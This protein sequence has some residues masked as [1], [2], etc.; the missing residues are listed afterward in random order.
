MKSIM[1]RN[2]PFYQAIK[3]WQSLFSI[4][5][6]FIFLLTGHATQAQN[7]ILQGTIIDKETREVIPFGVI[8]LQNTKLGTTTD[9]DG[10]YKLE[11]IPPTV[12]NIIISSLGYAEMVVQEVGISG[13]KPTVLN[14]ELSP[15][16][17]ELREAEVGVSRFERM[18]E[19]P[20]SKI[21]IRAAEIMRNPGGNRDISK[22]IQSFPGVASSVSFRNDLIIRG[23]APNE[24]RFYLDGIE[25]PNINHF[26]TQ[27]S[28]GGPVGLINVNFV[29]DVD[30]YSGAFPASRGNT[31]SS[32][33]EF[34]QK[35]G[36]PDRLASTLMVGSSDFGLTLDGPISER[37]DFIFSVRR[38]YLQFLFAA[39]K[40]PFLP[41]YTDAQFKFNYRF[42]ENNTIT[43]I[44]LGAFDEFRLNKKVND[45]EKDAEIIELNNYLLGNL[46]VND[47]WNYTLGVKYSHFGKRGLQQI[48]LSRNTLNNTAQ[49]FEDNDDTD[50]SKQLLNYNSR[51]TEN[52]LR[53][54]NTT[55][56]GAYKFSYGFQYE[57]VEYTNST[58]TRMYLPSGIAT[59]D[60]SSSLP[61]QKGGGYVQISR[62]FL[63]DRLMLSS[64]IRSDIND[65]SSK[66]NDPLDQLSP[67]F[68]VSYQFIEKWF[69][70]AN[71]GR[72]FQ[73]PPYT[74]LGYRDSLNVLVNK[75]NN[76]KYISSDHL[77]VGLE[78]LRASNT[79]ISLEGFYKRYRNYP[80]LINEQI[81]L[82]NLGSDFGV[83]GD[84]PV[85][86][87]S[88]G[89]SYGVELMIQ[90]S[91]MKGYYGIAAYTYVRSEFT[92]GGSNY[93]PSSW[94]NRHI[95]SLTG[96]KQ[97]RRNWEIGVKFRYFSGA[98][99]TPFDQQ[100]SARIDVWDIT[101]SGVPNYSAINTQR[102]P[103]SHQLDIRIDKKYFLKKTV[104]NIYLDIQNL[105]NNKTVL[106][107]YLTVVTD[108]NGA[109]VEDPNNSGS[110]LLKE[111]K[112]E[113]GTILPSIGIMWEF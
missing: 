92:N 21:N 12:Y 36:N 112:N 91:I 82:A 61:L 95:L 30:F 34:R 85:N 108:K 94:D 70:N 55:R 88:T 23:G 58:F 38:S 75:R 44:G 73:L 68:S 51:E 53:L 52:K 29:N 33:L 47:Q 3:K 57:Y 35:N 25:V 41:T 106:A 20:L 49:K 11:S 98:P 60:Y 87:N 103:A 19:A 2:T 78:H 59:I 104:L 5:V 26:A 86:S 13:T 15:I 18:E 14:I 32:V 97:L 31:L 77:V 83:I 113:S 80:L 62:I 111:L 69:L 66:M 63:A 99:F 93:V 90:Q 101:R 39:L 9:I 100:A 109:A 4:V 74:S 84:E 48:I 16:K 43:V 72:Y 67:R 42:N 102:L 54:E 64:G 6:L 7:G 79:K 56:Y 8:R 17:I 71:M 89:R 50:P 28:S 37:G 105:Y 81:S 27:G 24:N 45:G 46:P 76:L 1:V 40:L 107:P 22:V 110:Y 96:G 10:K 65:Y